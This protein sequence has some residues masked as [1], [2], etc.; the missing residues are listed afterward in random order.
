MR[1]SFAPCAAAALLALSACN[2]ES[3]KDPVA[4]AIFQNEKSIGDANVT[5]RQKQDAEFVVTAASRSMLDM[6]ISQIAQRKAASPDVK[7]LAQMIAGQHGTMQAALTQLAAKKGL[8]LPKGLGA[9]QAKQ[10]GELTALNG[11]AFDRRYV[12]LLEEVHK[13]SIDD[14]DDMSDDAYDGD[15]RTFAASQLP[16]L[17]NHLEATE[18]M[19]DL[20]PK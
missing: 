14:F 4:E 16:T 8:V 18:K 6:E 11:A 19:A 9:D 10:A 2:T 12:E 13:A 15:I 20:L 7:Y 3:T 17:K 1:F 5:E